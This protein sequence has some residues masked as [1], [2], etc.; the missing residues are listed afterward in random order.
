M[1]F[2]TNEKTVRQFPIFYP[3]RGFYYF[4]FKALFRYFFGFRFNV[5]FFFEKLISNVRRFH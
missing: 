3:L 4:I 2:E 1:I 5:S